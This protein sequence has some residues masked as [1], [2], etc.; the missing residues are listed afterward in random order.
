MVILRDMRE[1]DVDDYVRWFTSETEWSEKWDAPWEGKIE[2]DPIKERRSWMEYFS[3]VKSL[4]DD[5]ERWKFEIE[6]NGRHIGWVSSYYDLDYSDNP[7]HIIA[8]GIDIPDI[9]ARGKGFGTKALSLFLEY[10]KGKGHMSFFIQT[11]SK[12]VPMLKVIKKLGFKESVRKRGFLSVGGKKCDA[13]T[14]LLRG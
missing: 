8:V 10:L 7:D 11:W 4:N 6:A 12:N 14:F 5:M 13:I 9:D 1:S 2:G 3:S